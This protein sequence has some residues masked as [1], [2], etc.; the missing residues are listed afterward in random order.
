MYMNHVKLD[1][2]EPLASEACLASL[3]EALLPCDEARKEKRR[4]SAVKPPAPP[5]LAGF[6]WLAGWDIACPWPLAALK[7]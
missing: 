1:T 6:G 2:C 7:I 4:S 5:L 3:C